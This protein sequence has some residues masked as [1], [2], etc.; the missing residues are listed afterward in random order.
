MYCCLEFNLCYLNNLKL[1][2]IRVKETFKSIVLKGKVDRFALFKSIFLRNPFLINTTRFYIKSA[3]ME[4]YLVF[5]L[6]IDKVG[7]KNIYGVQK[8][9]TVIYATYVQKNFRFKI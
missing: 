1:F 8:V 9:I 6:K 3:K 5:N 7:T 2:S 4:G